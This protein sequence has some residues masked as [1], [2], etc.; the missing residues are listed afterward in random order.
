MV[1]G[2]KTSRGTR[3]VLTGRGRE[4]DGRKE[5]GCEKGATMGEG[6]GAPVE[7]LSTVRLGR[8]HSR[9]GRHF[10]LGWPGN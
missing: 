10:E 5:G 7:R 9:E 3:I 6:S 8:Q 1:A 4:Y 2:E